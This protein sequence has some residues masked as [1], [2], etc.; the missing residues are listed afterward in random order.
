[1]QRE[2][3]VPVV[4]NSDLF[5]WMLAGAALMLVLWLKL[6]AALLAGLLVYELAHLLGDRLK[7]GSIGRNN[8]RLMAVALLTTAVVV[9]LTLG[10]VGLASA[11]RHGSDS[12]PALLQKLAEIIDSS[13]QQLPQGMNDYLPADADELRDKL[14]AW[15]RLHSGELGG[16][17]V[18]AG[19]VFAHILIGMVIGALLALH[20]PA[21]QQPRRPLSAAIATHVARLGLAFRR[22]VFA[23][24]WIA[25][26][27]AGVT[28]LYLFV[29]LPVFGVHLPL[30]K[31]L[32]AL[33]FVAGLIPIIGNLV[34]N[35]A[36]VV[37]SVSASLHVAVA[38]LVFL[39]AV[40]KLQY[41]LNAR[42][43]GTQIRAAAWELL[44]VMLAMEAAFGVAGVIAA[45]IYY[46]YFKEELASKGLV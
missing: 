8:A 23:Q 43:I 1:M 13:R 4:A 35:A 40:H 36:I 9:L 30:T 17:G 20:E 27:N 46:A 19:R 38:S 18:I 29:A 2:R 26:I 45:P 42:I 44:L 6:L 37:V 7:L 32:L 24:T 3:F 21:G 31:T 28:A 5:T 34:S 14:A 25:A 10:I 15:L 12:L 39:I 11:L 33:T 22:V 41:F 16:A